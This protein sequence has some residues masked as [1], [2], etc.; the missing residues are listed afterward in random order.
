MIIDNDF[1]LSKKIFKKRGAKQRFILIYPAQ[2]Y[3]ILPNWY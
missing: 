3:I 1:T 2:E